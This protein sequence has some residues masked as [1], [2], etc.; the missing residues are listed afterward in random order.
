MMWINTLSEQV[1]TTDQAQHDF[2][3]LKNKKIFF[4]YDEEKG[5]GFR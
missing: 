3:I 2:L 5:T 1:F 4:K